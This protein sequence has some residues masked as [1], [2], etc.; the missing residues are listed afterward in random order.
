MRLLVACD[1]CQRQYEATSRQV[2]SRFHCHCGNAITIA[3][4]IGHDA[5]V[6]RCSSCGAPRESGAAAC[7]FCGGDFTLH[8]RK[9][10]VIVDLCREDGV[11]F[12]ADELLRILAWIRGGGSA[13]AQQQRAEAERARDRMR[14]ISRIGTDRAGFGQIG[15]LSDDAPPRDGFD[16]VVRVLSGIFGP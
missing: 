7:G 2:G 9:S 6:V 1:A 14:G 4:P 8:G 12:D 16:L 3:Q 15:S 5:S 10:G 13:R 11:W